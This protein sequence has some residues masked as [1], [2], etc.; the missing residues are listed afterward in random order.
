MSNILLQAC[1]KEEIK[2]QN[3]NEVAVPFE[4]NNSP[5][6]LFS[7]LFE[8]NSY[9]VNRILLLP[10]RKS[11]EAVTNEDI[12]FIPDF[13]EAKQFDINSFPAYA[14]MLNLTA[15]Y[16]YKVM[17]IGYNRNDYNFANPATTGTRFAINSISSPTQLDNIQLSLASPVSTPEFFVCTCDASVNNVSLGNIFIPQQNLKLSG[18]LKRI[19]S[20]L[21]LEIINIPDFVDSISLVAEQLVTAVKVKDAT[22]TVW[23]TAGDTGNKILGIQTPSDNKV[24]FGINLLPSFDAHKAKLFLDI[25]YGQ[26]TDRYTVKVNDVAGVSSSNSII[27]L[28]N[29]VVNITGDYS[30]IDIGFTISGSINLDDD[31]WD[32]L[33]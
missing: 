4:I 25:H 9:T 27:F 12:N 28:P 13:S 17:V 14:T 32:G 20:G 2:I 16:S 7:I 18:S 23:Q 15:G 24:S 21:S 10:F 19:V 5:E 31:S 33:Q 3:K 8:S 6:S 22:A 26:F 29:Q 30:N 11:N 1:S